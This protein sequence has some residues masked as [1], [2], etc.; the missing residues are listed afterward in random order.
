MRNRFDKKSL[1][2]LS[3]LIDD[4]GYS[5]F[6]NIAKNSKRPLTC[7]EHILNTTHR[8]DD[9]SWSLGA[10]AINCIYHIEKNQGNIDP[11]WFKSSKNQ[12]Y[13]LN[14]YYGLK[15]MHEGILV[16]N[17][18]PGLDA[19]FDNTLWA[20]GLWRHSLLNING[21]S[22]HNPRHF[23]GS[24]TGSQRCTFIPIDY[25]YQYQRDSNM[26]HLTQ[27]PYYLARKK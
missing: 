16:A 21:A 5:A 13:I 17:N 27:F 8:T 6:Q 9:E 14:N 2:L 20:G 7:L 3:D 11:S 24:G 12:L 18:H 26:K 10:M 15:V 19:L 1:K 23:A 22:K 25:I 4:L